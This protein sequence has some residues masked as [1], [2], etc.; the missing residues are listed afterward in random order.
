MS[1][2]LNRLVGRA[3]GDPTDTR[4]KIEPVRAPRYTSLRDLAPSEPWKVPRPPPEGAL[5]L[6]KRLDTGPPQSSDS[7]VNPTQDEVGAVLVSNGNVSGRGRDLAVIATAAAT[8]SASQTSSRGDASRTPT[9]LEERLDRDRSSAK[10]SEIPDPPQGTRGRELEPRAVT[11]TV[12]HPPGRAGT[13]ASRITPASA[14][15]EAST[16]PSI[17]ISIGHVE[18]RSKPAPASPPPLQR[19]PAFRPRLSLEAFL[20]RD[21]GRKP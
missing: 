1:D 6:A 8:P 9:P 10:L 21:G 5:G 12:E 15:V 17:V 11:T 4:L 14:P 18:V 13:A 7:S 2:L 19:R 20:G 16:G 3:R